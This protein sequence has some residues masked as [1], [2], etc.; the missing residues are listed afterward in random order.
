MSLVKALFYDF[1]KARRGSIRLSAASVD[2]VFILL[3]LVPTMR[4]N[5]RAQL[6]RE[7]QPPSRPEPS[8]LHS[9]PLSPHW[10]GMTLTLNTPVTGFSARHER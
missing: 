5:L 2:E 6:D 10:T 4:M 7:V 1:E 3:A 9:R 8:N